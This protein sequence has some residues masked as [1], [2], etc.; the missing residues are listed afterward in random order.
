MVYGIDQVHAGDAI[1]VELLLEM[2][3]RLMARTRFEEYGGRFR[4]E[5]NWIG[6]SDYNPCNAAFVPPPPEYVEG[7][8]DDLIVF[9][10]DESLSPVAQ[11]GRVARAPREDTGAFRHG[12]AGRGTGRSSPWSPSAARLR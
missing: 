5:Q 2:H 8:V 12:S 9:A 6:G 7:L 10:N 11:A 1:T 4:T 3:R